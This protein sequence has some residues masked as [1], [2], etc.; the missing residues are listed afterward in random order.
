[1]SGGHHALRANVA[2]LAQMAAGTY[3]PPKLGLVTSYDGRAG[4]YAV[5]VK[6]MPEEIETGWLPIAVLMAGQAWGVY[7]APAIGDQALVLYQEGDVTTGVCVGFLPSD[8]DQAPAVMPGEIHLIAR[9][10]D[11]SVILRADGSIASKGTWSHEGTFHAT[12][13]I[14][15]DAEL[16]DHSG[17]TESELRDSYNAHKHSGVTTG[18][19]LSGTTDNPAA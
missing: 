3:A 16:I 7:A 2:Q 10:G 1:M 18:G 13:N 15:T 4:A 12:G 14:S 11:A 9:D 8:E 17:V 19:A 6:L 5:K